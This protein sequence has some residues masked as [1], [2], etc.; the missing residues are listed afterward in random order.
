[1]SKNETA[2]S[3][4][5]SKPH[6]TTPKYSKYQV[7]IDSANSPYLQVEADGFQKL[8][9]T[10]DVVFIKDNTPVLLVSASK[11]IALEKVG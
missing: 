3:E 1:M 11:F 9:D 6:I 10:G 2:Q 4:N 5:N 8:K 7:M